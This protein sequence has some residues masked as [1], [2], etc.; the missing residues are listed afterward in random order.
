MIHNWT[1]DSVDGCGT[2]IR[3]PAQTIP[4]WLSDLY[5]DRAPVTVAYRSHSNLGVMVE[6]RFTINFPVLIECEGVAILGNV[7][8]C[9]KAADGGYVLGIKINQIVHPVRADVPAAPSVKRDRSIKDRLTRAA[10]LGGGT[11][12][13]LVPSIVELEG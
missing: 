12:R 13:L 9:L 7:R 1:A 11:W 4:A 6:D 3:T 8:H 5:R 10:R 2:R